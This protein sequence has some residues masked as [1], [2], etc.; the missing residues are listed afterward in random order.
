[1]SRRTKYIGLAVIVV[2]IVAGVVLYALLKTNPGGKSSNGSTSKVTPVSSMHVETAEP[3]PHLNAATYKLKVSGLVNQ[4]LELTLLDVKAIPPVRKAVTLPCVEGWS[5]Y[6]FWKGARL[7]DVLAR[8]GIGA[9]ARTVVFKDPT[10]YSTSLTVDDVQKTD[11]ILA[12]EV[13]GQQLPQVQGFPVRLVVPHKL[14]YKWIK[15]VTDI[16]LIKGSYSGYWESRGY[17]NS[18]DAP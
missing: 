1:L 2:L 17:S 15:W 11:P 6:A 12:Y 18:A 10:G 4:P 8:A 3:E 14:G 9:E 5:E 16:K 13:N 7:K